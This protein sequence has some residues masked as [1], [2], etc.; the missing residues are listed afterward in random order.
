MVS[1]II[2]INST[3]VTNSSFLLVPVL[4]PRDMKMTSTGALPQQPLWRGP[5]GENSGEALLKVKNK[6]NTKPHSSQGFG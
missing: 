1:I 4:C 3:L 2:T 6:P 5:W